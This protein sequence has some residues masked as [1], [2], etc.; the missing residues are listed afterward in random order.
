MA[1]NKKKLSFVIPCYR[2]ELTIRTVVDEI[3]ETLSARPEYEYEIILVDDCSPD[4]V[5]GVIKE[6][7]AEDKNIHGLSFAKNFGQHSALLAG[8]RKSTGD[9][10]VCLDDD[11]QTPANE[12]FNLVDALDC[13]TDVVYASYKQSKKKHSAVR[14]LGSKFN[15]FMLR[16]V[17]SKPKK[18]EVSSF[19]AAKRYVVEE[20]C[21]YQ[22]PFPYAIGLMLRTT[23]KIKNV[24]VNHRAREVGHSGYTFKKLVSLW[25]NGFTAFSVVP[26]RMATAAGFVFSAI[27][28]VYAV[29]LVVKKIINP[30]VPMGYSSMMAVLLVVGGILMLLVGMLG[31]YVGRVYMSINKNPQYVVRSDTDKND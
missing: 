17:L 9:I 30:A 6:L 16:A 28:F 23:N 15:E 5:Y 2:S 18:L 20:A 25:V 22:N 11:G 12:I 29:V 8:M 21:S 7:S 14:N 31:E 24:P 1:E 3:R 27:G 4:K 26:L 10:V 19:F 13:D